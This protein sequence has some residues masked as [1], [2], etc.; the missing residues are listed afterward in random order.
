MMSSNDDSSAPDFER[1]YHNSAI[2]KAEI[3]DIESKVLPRT[4]L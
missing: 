2:I 1:P 3:A 4:S